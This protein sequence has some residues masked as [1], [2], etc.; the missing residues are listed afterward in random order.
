MTY[1]APKVKEAGPWFTPLIEVNEHEGETW[2][3]WIQIDGNQDILNEIAERIEAGRRDSDYY[4]EYSLPEWPYGEKLG[5]DQ[6]AL[7]ERWSEGGYH[8][9]HNAV[10]G[11][12]VRPDRWIET[13]DSESVYVR[14]DALYKG[15]I[16]DWKRAE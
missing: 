9:A 8:P 12:L 1:G 14:L 13:A 5:R 11:V 16:S 7:L 3:W 6:V 4:E 10:T 15:G 2:T